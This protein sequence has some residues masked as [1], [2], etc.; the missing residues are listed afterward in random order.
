MD[1]EK[2]KNYIE[3]IERLEENKADISEDIKDILAAAKGEGFDIKAMRQVLRL[4]RKDKE[5]RDDELSALEVYMHA[6]DM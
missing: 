1:R 6:L 2:L 4:R 3:R 5:E